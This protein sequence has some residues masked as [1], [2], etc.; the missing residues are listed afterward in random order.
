MTG[1]GAYEKTTQQIDE[2]EPR[3]GIA[4]H[5]RILTAAEEAALNAIDVV[6]NTKDDLALR[7]KTTGFVSITICSVLNPS[8]ITGLT[9]VR[10]VP[11]VSV[12]LTTEQETTMGPLIV[13]V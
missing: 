9:A 1:I 2:P 4:L 3:D 10:G 12:G 7:F 13:L 11:I 8:F 5:P 6:F